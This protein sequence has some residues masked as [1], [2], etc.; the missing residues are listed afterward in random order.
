MPTLGFAG[1]GLMGTPLARR[2]LAAGHAVWVWNRSPDKAEALRADGAQPASLMEMA[3][4]CEIIFLCLADTAAVQEVVSGAQGLR[5][6]LRPGQ[7]VVDLSSIDP[8]AT[9]TLAETVATCGA[10]WVDAPVSGGVRG[11]QEGRLVVMAGGEAAALERV[12]PYLA[13]FAQRV[14]RMGGSGAGQ[15]TKVCNQLIVATQSLLIAEAVSL[16]E[17]SGVDASLLAPALAGGFADSLPFQIL[18]PRMAHRSHAP[19]QW[20]VS[21]LLKDL[22]NALQVARSC[23]AAVPLAALATQLMRMVAAG[24]R[25]EADLSEV[26]AL[27]ATAEGA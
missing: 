12:R 6:S 20:K 5:A 9:R 27:Y 22:E 14:T 8:A 21:T 15:L 11:A 17:R 25:S 2:L 10:R 26:I 13:A 23:E 18:A 19:V 4:T 3:A 24:G 7:V 16:A 1:L